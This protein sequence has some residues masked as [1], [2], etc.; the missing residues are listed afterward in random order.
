MKCRKCGKKT[1][2]LATTGRSGNITWNDLFYCPKCFA[3]FRKKNRIL[4]LKE[5]DKK[6]KRL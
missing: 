3:E 1:N 5:W 2:T 4:S 6:L